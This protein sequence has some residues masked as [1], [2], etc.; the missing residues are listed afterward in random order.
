MPKPTIY[1]VPGIL[2]SALA[3]VNPAKIAFSGT[4]RDYGDILYWLI[5]NVWPNPVALHT[6]GFRQLQMAPN[7]KDPAFPTEYPAVVPT[8]LVVGLYS[9]M[10]KTLWPIGNV[11]PFPYDWRLS[12]TTAATA[13]AAAAAALPKGTDVYFVAHSMGGLVSRK[14]WQLL[15]NENLGGIVKRIV[16]LGTPHY[17]SYGSPQAMFGAGAIFDFCIALAGFGVFNVPPSIRSQLIDCLQSCWACMELFPWR[18]PGSPDP[19][20]QTS[21]LVWNLA[22]YG[23]YATTLQQAALDSAATFQADMPADE[24]AGLVACVVGIGQPT[25]SGDQANF[26]DPNQASWIQPTGNGDGQVETWSALYPVGAPAL[27]VPVDH[28]WLCVDNRVLSALPGILLN[29]ITENINP[30]GVALPPG[31]AIP[32]IGS[33]SYPFV[34]PDP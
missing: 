5:N 34:R 33:Q 19:W 30:G 21:P 11:V 31:E 6:D 16:T 3:V 15:V 25:A 8:D 12:N 18:T 14:A 4:A 28:S 7:G 24:P 23:K 20:K 1:V 17:G 32:P 10:I 13:L 2:S 29:G 26:G 22:W 9:F 27:Y